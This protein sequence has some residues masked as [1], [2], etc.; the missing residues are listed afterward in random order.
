MARGLTSSA[1]TGGRRTARSRLADYE[2]R[3]EVLNLG[4]CVPGARRAPRAVPISPTGRMAERMRVELKTNCRVREITVD[5]NDMATGVDLL[6]RTASST[7]QRAEVV[8]MACNGVGTPRL[9]LNSVS[10]RFPDGLANRVRSGGQESDVASRG[11]RAGRVRRATGFQFGP[12]GCCLWSQEFYETDP[13]RD[14]VRGYNMQITRGPG[15]INTALRGSHR[16]Y[17]VGQ[18]HHDAF[19]KFFGRTVNLGICCEDLPEEHNTVTLDPTSRIR[20]ASR[21]RR[22]PTG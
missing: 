5:D 1:G 14:F 22:S 7:S 19:G 8:I 11:A 16:R 4:P 17:P 2:G 9:L 21:R 20:T 10:S 12:Q 15:P 3:D 13:A 6:R 18:G